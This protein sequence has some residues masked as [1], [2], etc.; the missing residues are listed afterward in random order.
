MSKKKLKEIKQE[1]FLTM[2]KWILINQTNE[3]NVVVKGIFRIKC[4]HGK[5]RVSVHM[6]SFRGESLWIKGIGTQKFIFH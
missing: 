2:I 4:F 6:T 3:N 1:L 5:V